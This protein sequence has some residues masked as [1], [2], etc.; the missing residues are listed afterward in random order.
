MRLAVSSICKSL[1]FVINKPKYHIRSLCVVQNIW[2]DSGPLWP[3]SAIPLGDWSLLLAL[4]HLPGRPGKEEREDLG[5]RFYCPGSELLYILLPTF[6]W[7]GLSHMAYQTKRRVFFFFFSVKEEITGFGEYNNVSFY[8]PKTPSHSFSPDKGLIHP[9]PNWDHPR[10]H[11][12]HRMELKVQDLQAPACC[13]SLT[14]RQD[15]PHGCVTCVVAQVPRLR[16][17][18]AIGLM[19]CAHR[20]EM[21]NHLSFKLVFWKWRTMG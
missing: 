17:G 13:G 16:W 7:T 4:Q 5:R 18:P 9:L 3:S 21:T 2:W 11:P 10:S 20:H 1:T 8:S 6:P 19:L 14:S 12:C 15:W